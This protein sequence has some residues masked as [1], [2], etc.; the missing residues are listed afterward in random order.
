[1]RHVASDR[2]FHRIYFRNYV[3][4]ISKKLWFRIAKMSN[5]TKI[6]SDG[7]FSGAINSL[8][9][10][11]YFNQKMSIGAKLW[12]ACVPFTF[13]GIHFSDSKLYF[14]FQLNLWV[15]RYK[16]YLPFVWSTLEIYRLYVFNP[17]VWNMHI[18]LNLKL[19]HRKRRM[20]LSIFFS[21]QIIQYI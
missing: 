17:V 10:H 2:I 13:F 4:T 20:F 9:H 7:R 8:L 6:A 11:Q 21:I 19:I 15:D 3:W 14:P 16:L 1:M 12:L 5:S 18:P